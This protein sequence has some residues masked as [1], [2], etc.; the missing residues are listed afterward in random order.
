MAR[1]EI[2]EEHEHEHDFG[3]SF[4]DLLSAVVGI[5][6]ILLV[7]FMSKNQEETQKI[8]EKYNKEIDAI[9]QSEQKIQEIVTIRSDIVSDI[10][11]TFDGSK[12]GIVV[13]KESGAIRFSDKVLFEINSDKITKLGKDYLN[14]FIPEY[15]NTLTKDMSM[16][17][18]SEIVIEGHTDDAGSYIYNLD[19]SQ[20]RALAVSNYILSAEM[21]SF[22]YKSEIFKYLTATGKSF[23]NLIK[24]NNVINRDASRRV[25][26]KFRLKDEVFIKDIGN[27]L[28]SQAQNGK[29]EEKVLKKQE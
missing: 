21:P 6:L 13:E 23:S 25:E 2:E 29:V 27:I 10:V 11:K 7:Y 12:L 15:M 1:K 14:K 5:F 4:A 9:K 24:V 3:M 26:F 18:L 8:I 17:N 20:R 16:K 19:L 22:K 28:K